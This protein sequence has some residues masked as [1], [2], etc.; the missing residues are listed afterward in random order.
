MLVSFISL[1]DVVLQANFSLI[2]SVLQNRK[3]QTVLNGQCST[4]GDILAGV[5]QGSILGLL[6]FPVYI[7]DLT[8]TLKCIVKLFADDT[9]LFTIVH[10]PN[11]ASEE[12]NHDL[13]LISQWAHDLRMSFNPDLQKQAIEF[14]VTKKR[15][16]ADHPVILYNNIPVKKVDKHKHLGI[17]LDSKRSFSSHIKSAISKT[18]R[19]IGLLKYLSQ[20]LSRH[21]LNNLYKLYVRPHLDYGEN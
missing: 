1:N 9:S 2:Q 18:R 20:Y 16:Q 3:Q 12:M 21:T 14:L 4:W 19:G 15:Q 11:L 7:K 13:A 8:A 17:I 5:S 10:K 6:L